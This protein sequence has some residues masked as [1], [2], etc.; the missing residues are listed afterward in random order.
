[1]KFNFQNLLDILTEKIRITSVEFGNKKP[2]TNKIF[3]N[4]ADEIFTFFVHED[5][6]AVVS[7]EKET[8]AFN[9]SIL[10]NNEANSRQSISEIHFKNMQNFY[11]EVLYVFDKLCKEYNINEFS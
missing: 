7:Y 9:F 5:Q 4:T 10:E 2:F 11:G 3:S 8:K 6:I 1:M